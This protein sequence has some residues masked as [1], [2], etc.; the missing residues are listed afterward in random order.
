MHEWDLQRVLT[1]QWTECGL[2]IDGQ[3]Q[4]LVAWEVMF[5]SWLINDPEQHFN[6]PSL[7][8][9]VVDE[10]GRLTVIE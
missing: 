6:E 9:L 8:F 5:S 4:M 7:D 1:K 2:A 10:R 3:R